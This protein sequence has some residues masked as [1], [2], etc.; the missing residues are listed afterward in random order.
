MIF[1]IFSGL[2]I[3]LPFE[4]LKIED[5][6]YLSKMLHLK[7]LR[8]KFDSVPDHKDSILVAVHAAGRAPVLERFTVSAN[9]NN[10]KFYCWFI[11]QYAYL[12]PRKKLILEKHW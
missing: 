12:Y 8:L 6:E 9:A 4:N 10:T 5:V 1:I 7:I 2:E 11:K 3:T